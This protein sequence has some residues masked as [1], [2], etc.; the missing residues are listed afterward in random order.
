M[1]TGRFERSLRSVFWL[2]AQ[3]VKKTSFWHFK[4]DI[5]WTCPEEFIKNN[6]KE[7]VFDISITCTEKSATL[8]GSVILLYPGLPPSEINPGILGFFFCSPGC[9]L[10]PGFSGFVCKKMGFFAK[11]RDF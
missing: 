6:T 1:L 8:V 10:C 3:V 11:N 7:F 2:I 5:L 4:M 9:F